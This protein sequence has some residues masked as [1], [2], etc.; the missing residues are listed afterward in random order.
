MLRA[1]AVVIFSLAGAALA[2]DTPP[3][4]RVTL[5]ASGGAWDLYRG[6][7][8]FLTEQGAEFIP[9]SCFATAG[10]EAASMTFATFP[11]VVRDS[12]RGLRNR[13]SPDLGGCV[14]VPQAHGRSHDW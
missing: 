14:Q 3:V 12:A 11:S 9:D 8:P 6:D 10:N 7:Y 5:L 2:E 1:L 4:A 13:L